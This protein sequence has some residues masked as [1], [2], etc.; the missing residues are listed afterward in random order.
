MPNID[1]VL[2][3]WM[4]W[5]LLGGFPLLAMFAVS[6]ERA[7]V[8]GSGNKA[9]VAL[10]VAY[11]FWLTAGFLGIHRFYLRSRWG[12]AFIPLFCAI[13]FANGEVKQTRETI[14]AMRQVERTAN[15]E[16]R[17]ARDDQ[18]R[19]VANA[20]DRLKKAEVALAQAHEGTEKALSD[21]V[22]WNRVGGA[23][24]AAIAILLAVDAFL[25]PG[26]TR[27]SRELEL[28]DPAHRF[29]PVELPPDAA[30]VSAAAALASAPQRALE[31]VIDWI[32]RFVSYWTLLSIFVYYY[33]V[34]V[35]FMF[36]S[37][38]NWVHE[39]MFLMYGMQYLLC[40]AFALRS[41]SHVRVDVFYTKFSR[42]GKALADV[43]TSFF[44]F[45]FVGTLLWT[46]FT[47]AWQATAIGEVS[48]SEWGVQYWPIK[49]TM[50]I[51]AAL[52]LAQGVAH[53][54]RDIRILAGKY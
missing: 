23:F 50:P 21:Q 16:L 18:L 53:L 41:D 46:G 25:L 14:S 54:L 32:G 47:Y 48:F 43:L 2:P 36:N 13:V 40:G 17:G 34:V 7:A 27:R 1:F 26:L 33:E 49:L 42:R 39:S 35:R 6:R 30:G 22:Y 38:T 31:T 45:V 3:L 52:L 51:G 5:L 15:F 4:Y 11:V 8:A 29:K 20:A 19:N 28:L 10:S 9:G 44:F 24:G 12:F 37:P